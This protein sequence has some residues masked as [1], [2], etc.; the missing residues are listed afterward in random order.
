MVTYLQTVSK[1]YNVHVVGIVPIFTKIKCKKEQSA[2]YHVSLFLQ[3]F[4][5]SYV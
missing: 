2:F 5:Y 4:V 1:I 3:K